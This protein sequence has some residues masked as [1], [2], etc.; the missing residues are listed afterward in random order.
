MSVGL[1]FNWIY[2][3]STKKKQ[4]SRLNSDA[5]DAKKKKKIEN[6]LLS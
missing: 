3:Q 4:L 6:V 2:R 1:S 5:I